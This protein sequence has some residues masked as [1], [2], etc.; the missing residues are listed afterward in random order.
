LGNVPH[1]DAS[2]TIPF[3]HTALAATAST[4]KLKGVLVFGSKKVHFVSFPG[5]GPQESLKYYDVVGE[6][7]YQ[8][9]I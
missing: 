1:A 2:A 8:E 3:D 6:S 5:L 4:T 9:E 7:F